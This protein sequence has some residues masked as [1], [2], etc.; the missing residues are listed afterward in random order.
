MRDEVLVPICERFF[1]KPEAALRLLDSFFCEQ[2]EYYVQLNSIEVKRS[3]AEHY[4]QVH[5]Q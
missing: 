2:G 1:L 3:T 5:L 4:R